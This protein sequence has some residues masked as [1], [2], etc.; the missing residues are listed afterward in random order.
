MTKGSAFSSPGIAPVVTFVRGGRR[1]AASAP[2][3]LLA[4]ARA[5]GLP[6]ASSCRGAGICDACRVVVIADAHN[7]TPPTTFETGLPD[8]ERLACQARAEGPVTLTT[9]YW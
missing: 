4:A 9:R 7:L 8:S 6:L 1:Y 2:G 5:A 3:T